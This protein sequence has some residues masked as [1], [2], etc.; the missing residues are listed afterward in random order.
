MVKYEV[1]ND[2]TDQKKKASG[3][4]TLLRLHRALEFISSLLTKIRVTDNSCKFSKEATEAYDT[5]LAKFHPWVIK[6]AVHVAMYTLPDRQNMLGKMKI[7]DTEDGMGKVQVLTD[8]LN[9]VYG[10]TQELYASNSLLD[11]P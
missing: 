3:C 9:A 5:T 11:L 4:R 1:D 6:K 8:Q 2:L 10:I 7:P